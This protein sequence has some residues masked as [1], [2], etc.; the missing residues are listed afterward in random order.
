[1]KPPSQSSFLRYR[2]E[3][4]NELIKNETYYYC[5]SGILRREDGKKKPHKLAEK[6]H[7]ILVGE[8]TRFVSYVFF[9]KDD[10]NAFLKGFRGFLGDVTVQTY[11]LKWSMDTTLRQ[12]SKSPLST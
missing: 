11:S 1:M 12:P 10:I 6:C 9:C 3:Q 7:G 8:A 4:A 2:Y 5:L